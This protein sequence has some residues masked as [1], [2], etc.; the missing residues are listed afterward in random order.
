DED[1]QIRWRQVLK[2]Q[3]LERLQQMDDLI[4]AAAKADKDKPADPATTRLIAQIPKTFPEREAKVRGEL[5][6]R[7]ASRFA[8]LADVDKLEPTYARGAILKPAAGSK[9]TKVG[10]IY[11]PG[12]Y[13]DLEAKKDDDRNAAADVRALVD[14]FEAKKI[15]ALVLD[16]RSNGGGILPHARDI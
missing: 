10:Y 16:V 9:D 13:G 14:K 6:V 8:R 3:A 4:D 12:F 2:Q 15:G 5:A 7:F 11:L 1:L